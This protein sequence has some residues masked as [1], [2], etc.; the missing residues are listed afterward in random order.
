MRMIVLYLKQQKPLLSY[1]KH[2]KHFI[3]VKHKH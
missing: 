2:A 1:F 3:T